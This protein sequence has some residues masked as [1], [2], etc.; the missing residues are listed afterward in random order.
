[1][2]S[3]QRRPGHERLD[4][5]LNR[6]SRWSQRRLESGAGGPG[7]RVGCQDS[8]AA[9]SGERRIPPLRQGPD[10]Q[11]LPG[12]QR[13]RIGGR[14]WQRAVKPFEISELTQDRVC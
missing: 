13:E 7:Q 3:E 9:Q 5:Q 8:G 12:E 2:A 4:P 6:S 1:M 11:H 10:R 14:R